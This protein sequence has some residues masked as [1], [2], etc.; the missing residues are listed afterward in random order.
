MPA[1]KL[2]KLELQIMDKLW[3]K[4]EASIREIQEAFPAKGRPS[5]TT[6]QMTIYRMELKKVVSRVRK[7][8]NFY[9]FA[10]L[11]SREAAEQRLVDELV[12]LFGGRSQ[13]VMSHLVR[14]GKLKLEEVREV[15]KEL[16]KKEKQS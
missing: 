2:S 14:S 7:V 4:N 6:I 9:I 13:L 3:T 12:S 1:P 15:E 8:G 10:A 16:L 11:V 5:Y